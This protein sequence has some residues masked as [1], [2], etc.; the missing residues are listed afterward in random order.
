MNVFGRLR[1][2]G[3]MK[4]AKMSNSSGKQTEFSQEDSSL[5]FSLKKKKN[6]HVKT[7]KIYTKST[8]GQML[9]I[10]SYECVI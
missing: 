5:H 7:A 3:G 2:F 10:Q 6:C 1:K 8:E 4:G 9:L